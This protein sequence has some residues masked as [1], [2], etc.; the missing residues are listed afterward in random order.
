VA[1]VNNLVPVFGG[2]FGVLFLGEPVATYH[3]TAAALVGIGI[4]CAESGRR[5][6]APSAPHRARP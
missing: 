1:P 2:L 5:D 3:L 6:A 4:C